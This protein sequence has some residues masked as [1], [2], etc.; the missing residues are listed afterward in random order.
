MIIAN[1]LVLVNANMAIGIAE[2]IFVLY[3][4]F[5]VSPVKTQLQLVLPVMEIESM[6]CNHNVFVQED[7][8]K[9]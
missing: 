5:N 8:M 3:A 6:D 1:Q 2:S 7:I 4:V 9:Y